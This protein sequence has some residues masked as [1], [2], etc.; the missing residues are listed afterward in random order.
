MMMVARV[1]GAE[2][3]KEAFIPDAWQRQN[4]FDLLRFLFAFVVSSIET[5]SILPSRNDMETRYKFSG[6][7]FL[8]PNQF[9]KH[10]NHRVVIEAL[11]LLRKEGKKVLVLTTGSTED[12]RNPQFFASLMAYANELGVLNDFRPLGLVPAN[13]LVALMLHAS[14]IINP[15]YF[16]GWSTSVEEAKSLGKRIV[17][18]D[19][20][21]HREQN[22]SRARYFSPD[23]AVALAVALWD[24]WN[25][26][27]ENEVLKLETARIATDE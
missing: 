4:N 23:D 20:A 17:V 6:E 18:S 21:V 13:D 7:Y 25:E 11:G 10:K 5:P 22:P 1:R 16:E 24:I 15:S 27:E 2:H 12:Y 14:A 3:P 8:L 19:I 26:P 9:W